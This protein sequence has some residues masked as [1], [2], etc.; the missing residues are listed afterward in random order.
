MKLE[1]RGDERWI[2]AIVTAELLWAA[3][4]IGQE[5]NKGD[6]V[7]EWEENE[8]SFSCPRSWNFQ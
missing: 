8:N 2:I 5:I 7:P 6:S 3:E 4:I 1:A